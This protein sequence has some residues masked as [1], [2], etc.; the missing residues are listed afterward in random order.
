MKKLIITFTL[1]FVCFFAAYS[2]NYKTAIGL[3]LGAPTSIS[4]KHF[5]NEKGALEA[6][7]GY[8]SWGFGSWFNVGGLYEHHLPITSV[9]GLQWY[10]GG[11]V[12][13]FFWNYD[14]AYNFGG[15]D[16]S[17]TSLGIMGAIGLDYKFANAPVN[18]SLDWLPLIYLGNGYYDGFG[19]GYGALSVRY[20]LK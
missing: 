18:L 8:R 10:F 17:S 12:N 9:E 4:L 5:I 2:Q 13:A 20:T 11:G 1:V 7:V 3:R 19:G 16:Y 14:N 15:N 6:F